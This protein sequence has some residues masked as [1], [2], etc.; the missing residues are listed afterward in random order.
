MKRVKI[1]LK[2]QEATQSRTFVSSF[3]LCIGKTLQQRRKDEH[4]QSSALLYV[5][6]TAKL[7]KH[8]KSLWK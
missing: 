4:T 5:Q 6:D 1:P 7:A 3:E 8:L 2:T